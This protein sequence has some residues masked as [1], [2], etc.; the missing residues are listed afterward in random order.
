MDVAQPTLIRTS[1]RLFVIAIAVCGVAIV[2]ALSMAVAGMLIGWPIALAAVA[3]LALVFIKYNPSLCY[4]EIS[5]DALMAR[6]PFSRISIPWRDI[7][8]I[9]AIEYSGTGRVQVL[10]AEDV[11]Q[12]LHKSSAFVVLPDEQYGL[13]VNYGL[14]Y[15]ELAKRLD[16]YRHEFARGMPETR[17][18]MRSES[19]AAQRVKAAG[20][21]AAPAAEQAPAADDAPAAAAEESDA[22]E[23]PPA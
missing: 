17:A 5:E 23:R 22:D 3:M 2:A 1:P 11:E 4:L 9:D 19:M 10:C 8:S 6:T 14:D 7:L 15:R 20:A 13:A 16:A 21:Q 12:T 18:I